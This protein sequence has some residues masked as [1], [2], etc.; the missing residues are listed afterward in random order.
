MQVSVVAELEQH[1][2]GLF[3]HITPTGT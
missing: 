1:D 3:P 2:G